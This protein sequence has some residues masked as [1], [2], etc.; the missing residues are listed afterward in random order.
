[1]R[2]WTKTPINR[3]ARIRQSKASLP[4]CSRG[5][6]VTSQPS[7]MRSV[8]SA[9]RATRM[10]DHSSK[11]RARCS[12]AGSAS[13]FASQFLTRKNRDEVA[14]EMGLWRVPNL[15]AGG[16]FW[17]HYPSRA[18]PCATTPRNLHLATDILSWDNRGSS[19]A[20]RKYALQRKATGRPGKAILRTRRESGRQATASPRHGVP[21][22]LWRQ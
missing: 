22:L 11:G 1:M 4:N 12:S 2:A 13:S 8:P 3:P 17:Y 16:E 18:S 19:F 5:L 15:R 21:G 10:S 20:P 9:A 14:V 7:G 6:R